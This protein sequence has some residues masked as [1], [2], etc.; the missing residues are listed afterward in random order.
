MGRRLGQHFLVD[1]AVAD[2]IVE[3]AG[4]TG[5]E[6]VLEIGPGKGVLTRRL[7][8]KAKSVIAVELDRRLV[9]L[10]RRQ[11]ADNTRL[12]IIHSDFMGLEPLQ[13]TG[14]VFVANL[15]YYITSPILQKIISWPDWQRATVTIQKEVANRLIAVPGT[16]DYG[17]LTISVGIKAEAE[18]LLFVRRDAFWPK[19]SVDSS[20]V[21]LV[22]RQ[23]PLVAPADEPRFF[24]LLRCCFQQRRKTILNSLSAASGAA[25]PVVSAAL[26]AAGIA[27]AARA[28]ELDIPAF[29]RLLNTLPR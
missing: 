1:E 3:A 23:Q 9:A 29:L 20:V 28:E 19:P 10:L 13:E 26:E 18:K 5:R 24:I 11:Y 8:E 22:P 4:L 7:L 16:K 17:I 15:P 6:T 14:L 21:R 12:R 25:K 27:P 2:S